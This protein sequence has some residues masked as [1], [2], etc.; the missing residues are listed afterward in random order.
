MTSV[1]L[2]LI[3]CVVAALTVASWA[4]SEA[5]LTRRGIAAGIDAAADRLQVVMP[6]ECSP[7]VALLEERL[8]QRFLVTLDNG[9]TFN[10]LLEEVDDQ[11]VVLVDATLLREQQEP[12]K[13]AGA[14]YL[15]RERVV[16][17]QRP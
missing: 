9:E 11:V 13:V 8:L 7:P 12:A 6:A 3:L 10:G 15:P 5:R 4:V 14:L 17:L 1:E 2:V 16:Y